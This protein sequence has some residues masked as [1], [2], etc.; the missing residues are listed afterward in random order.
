[1]VA[2]DAFVTTQIEHKEYTWER[3]A[4]AAGFGA[5][6]GGVGAAVIAPLAAAT[7]VA[8]ASLLGVSALDAPAVAAG[9]EFVMGT[10]LAAETNIFIASAQR[11]ANQALEGKD[12][13]LETY[14]SNIQKN[15]WADAGFGALGYGIGSTVSKG[16][17]STFPIRSPNGPIPG[18][19]SNPTQKIIIGSMQAE[20][21]AISNSTLLDFLFKPQSPQPLPNQYQS[22]YKPVNG[23]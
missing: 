19:N 20:G 5:L 2:V 6:S 8:T 16:I 14:K 15:L 22:G 9:A 10:T 13:S 3:A 18:W 7:G 1:M 17:S 12:V 4:V 23:F 21:L 11:T